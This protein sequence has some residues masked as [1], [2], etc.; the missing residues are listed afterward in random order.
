M[1]PN[2][3]EQVCIDICIAVFTVA[4]LTAAQVE[5]AQVSINECVGE[6]K[7]VFWWGKLFFQL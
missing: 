4:Q 6:Q 2:I 7:L 5:I 3:H 1:T